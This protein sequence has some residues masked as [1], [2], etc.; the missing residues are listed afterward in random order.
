MMGF[1]ICLILWVRIKVKRYDDKFKAVVARAFKNFL[2][3]GGATILY[4]VIFHVKNLNLRSND[5]HEFIPALFVQLF[6][7]ANIIYL[8]KRWVAIREGLQSDSVAGQS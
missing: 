2:W 8:R 4:S 7:W 6:A 3:L 5:F 1:F